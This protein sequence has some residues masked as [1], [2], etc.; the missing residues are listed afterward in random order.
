MLRKGG[1]TVQKRPGSQ[2][3]C[4]QN[5]S[6][7]MAVQR[8]TRPTR[9][10]SSSH[11]S[12]RITPLSAFL[13]IIGVYSVGTVVWQT[14]HLGGGGS[15]HVSNVLT[16]T[17]DA[18]IQ[19]GSNN[20]RTSIA[21]DSSWMATSTGMMDEDNTD[22][23]GGVLDS[24]LG[25]FS[26][27]TASIGGDPPSNDSGTGSII[28]I[29]LSVNY[30]QVIDKAPG[31][32]P[33]PIMSQSAS[34]ARVTEDFLPVASPDEVVFRWA[35]QARKD[36]NHKD[37]QEITAYR[38]IVRQFGN[39]SNVVW[40]TNKVN[41]PGVPDSVSWGSVTPPIA[42]HIY[43]WKVLVWD[44][45]GASSSSLW[46]K[47]AVGPGSSEAW[48]GKW[49]VHPDD[50]D[51][52]DNSKQG[53]KDECNLWKKRR[54]LPI[55]RGRIS[56]D[57]ISGV[58]EIASALLV[59]SG[60]GSFRASFDGVPLSTSGPI[61]P[62]FTD[63]SK[64]VMYRGFDLTPFFQNGGGQADHTIGLTMGSGWWDHRPVSGMAK[65]KLLPRGPQ[66]TIAQ[67]VITDKSGQTRVIGQSGLGNDW[68]V[69]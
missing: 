59:V 49:I 61:D 48:E 69:T 30:L 32:P 23:G 34:S 63:Y 24:V 54:P 9:P 62:P 22:S 46:K 11:S 47:F 60:L 56:S 1:T 19:S 50:M 58:G 53:S 39:P 20:K 57:K 65:P 68:Q 2:T 27:M 15:T 13:V 6:R 33:E 4:N 41:G 31:A 51:T 64:R 52:F 18:F 45:A 14:L 8:K 36:A 3:A 42:G 5:D 28:P 40:D 37:A 7:D 25:S 67:V 43:E 55:F 26:S 35:F 44:A 10:L 17:K 21:S 16:R 29:N 66:T 38:I 12:Y